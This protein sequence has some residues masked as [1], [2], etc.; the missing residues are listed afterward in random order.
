MTRRRWLLLV[1]AVLVVGWLALAGSLLSGAARDLRDGRAAARAARADV[2]A[3]AI[4][5]GTSVPDLRRAHDR[6]RAAARATANPALLPVRFL[7]VAGRQL[8]SVH[9]LSAAARD[10]SGAAAEAMTRADDVL[11]DP[12]GGGPARVDEV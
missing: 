3:K 9:A 10:V 7:P 8:R 5:D 4:A 6:F 2:D 11:A 12:R 1:G